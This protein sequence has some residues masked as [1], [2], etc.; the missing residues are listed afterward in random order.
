MPTLAVTAFFSAVAVSAGLGART[1]LLAAAVL[2]GQMS[3]GW[4][5]DYVDAGR[6]RVA[7]RADKPVAAGEIS[8]TTVGGCAAVALAADVPLSLALGWRPGAAHLVAVGSAWLYDV[9]LKETVAS[10]LPFALSFGLVPV[11]I[12]TA[13]P[14]APLPQATLVAAAACCGVAAHFANTVGDAADDALTGVHG[15]PQ[16]LGPAAATALASGFVA[17]ASVLLVVATDAAWPAVVAAAVGVVA[18]VA[19]PMVLRRTTGR[20]VA[21]GLVIAAVAVLVAAFVVSGGHRLVAT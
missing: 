11:I 15:L 14:G 16:R 9:R 19:M 10:A 20:H 4:A 18:A 5:N 6:D 3:I 21:F 8:S 7:G 1:A 13:L 2:V 12:A 17:V